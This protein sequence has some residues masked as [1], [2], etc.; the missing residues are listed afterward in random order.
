MQC[1]YWYGTEKKKVQKC[2]LSPQGI[3]RMVSLHAGVS[4]REIIRHK[5]L[6][7]IAVHKNNVKKHIGYREK[8]YQ[9][10]CTSCVFH[11]RSNKYAHF[12]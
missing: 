6:L 4:T 7:E 1:D 3:K 8:L 5:T 10:L 11:H 12:G 9:N 2:I